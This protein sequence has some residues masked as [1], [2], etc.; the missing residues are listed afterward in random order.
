MKERGF[1]SSMDRRERS[2]KDRSYFCST[3]MFHCNGSAE[4]SHFIGVASAL[5]EFRWFSGFF[6]RSEVDIENSLL[7]GMMHDIVRCG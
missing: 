2:P 3:Q 6:E 1:F 4:V 5:S 7:D